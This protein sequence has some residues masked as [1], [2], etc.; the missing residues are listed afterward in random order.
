MNNIKV[1]SYLHTY[2]IKCLENYYITLDHNFL[3]LPRFSFAP[4]HPIYT[5][6]DIK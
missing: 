4:L 3:Q 5:Y 2:V 1:C 6:V